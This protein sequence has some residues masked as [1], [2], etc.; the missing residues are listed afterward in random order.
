MKKIMTMLL[1]ASVLVVISAGSVFAHPP[2]PASV[3]WDQAKGT[4]NISA[5]HRVNDPEKHYI[6]TLTVF[7]GN[8]QLLLKQYSRQDS[9]DGFND[10][11]ILK[12]VKP[13]SKIRIQL[14]CN[15]MGSSETEFTIP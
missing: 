2:K 13:G 4:L 6:L 14:V 3:S 11:V 8:R 5:Q 9:K 1:I 12:N 15:I 10:S 7:E